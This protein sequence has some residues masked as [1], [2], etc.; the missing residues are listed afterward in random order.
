MSKW[1]DVGMHGVVSVL[2]MSVEPVGLWAS[3]R[4]LLDFIGKCAGNAYKAQDFS[5][6]K[7]DDTNVARALN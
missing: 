5:E 3:E 4:D 6:C 2:P 7:A 1:K